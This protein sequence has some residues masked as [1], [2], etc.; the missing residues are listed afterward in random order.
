MTSSKITA[1]ALADAVMLLFERFAVIEDHCAVNEK[2][3]GVF[4]IHHTADHVA[5]DISDIN[6]RD[7]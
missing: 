2:H 4:E 7:F 6:K 3:V 1:P 5:M